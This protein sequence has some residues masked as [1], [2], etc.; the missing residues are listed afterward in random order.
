MKDKEITTPYDGEYYPLTINGIKLA[1]AYK[2]GYELG[3][4]DGIED[5]EMKFNFNIRPRLEQEAKQAII[6]EVVE[7][8]SGYCEHRQGKAGIQNMPRR[9]CED[10]WQSKLKE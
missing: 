7:W 8:A 5:A 1:D 9:Y 3:R 4:Q 2:Q 6:A 10:C